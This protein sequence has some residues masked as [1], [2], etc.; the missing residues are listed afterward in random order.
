M[1]DSTANEAYNEFATYDDFLDSQIAPM[2]IYYLE[3]Y[4]FVY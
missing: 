2:D 1:A 4:V 3:V